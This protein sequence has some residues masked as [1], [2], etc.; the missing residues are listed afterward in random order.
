MLSGCGLS[1]GSGLV[2]PALP[3]L[4]PRVAAPCAMT[5]A[6]AGDN[7]KSYAARVTGELA[8]CKAKHG[9]VVATYNSLRKGLAAK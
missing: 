2:K 1:L 7:A 3:E 9:N 4:D 6:R 8:A 5:T